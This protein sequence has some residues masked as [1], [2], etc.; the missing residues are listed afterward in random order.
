MSTFFALGNMG[1]QNPKP[2]RGVRRRRAVTPTLLR[3]AKR[4]LKKISGRRS[5]PR[6]VSARKAV[7]TRRANAHKR[8]LA[9]LKAA[10]TRKRRATAR[11]TARRPARKRAKARRNPSSTRARAR[12]RRLSRF[13][14]SRKGKGSHMARHKRRRRNPPYRG[15]G[16]RAVKVHAYPR[17]SPG[18]DPL[19]GALRERGV[20]VRRHSR[21][22]R[23]R[24]DRMPIP[25]HLS[26]LTPAGRQVGRLSAAQKAALRRLWEKKHN[27]HSPQYLAKRA[28]AAARGAGRRR[29]G[30]SAVKRNPHR[31]RRTRG[32]RRNPLVLGFDL[33]LKHLGFLAGGLLGGAAAGAAAQKALVAKVPAAGGVVARSVLIALLAAGGAFAAR[34]FGGVSTSD[35]TAILTGGALAALSNAV[36]AP[37][38]AALGLGETMYPLG[39]YEY[40]HNIP[41]HLQPFGLQGLGE[42]MY[43]LTASG[44]PSALSGL[45]S[46]D[47]QNGLPSH[48]AGPYGNL[49]YL[50]GPFAQLPYQNS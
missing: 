40:K 33:D 48:L 47:Y 41:T 37:L 39:D 7:R 45:G 42:T 38:N 18:R 1:V 2:R 17:V 3:R 8:H 10:R 49:P 13:S 35:A 5:N 23:G 31:R 24:A 20:V 16:A 34:K 4:A 22:R 11:K 44:D 27:R 26:R 29:K 15:A 28:A 30:A 14:S 50:N 6:R 32:R 9:A 25:K 43:P 36:A 21:A 46:F 12:A 19:T